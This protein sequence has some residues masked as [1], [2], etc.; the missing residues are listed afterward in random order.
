MKE[1]GRNFSGWAPEF[2][3]MIASTTAKAAAEAVVNAITSSG[4]QGN[5]SPPPP[6]SSDRLMAGVGG[7]GHAGLCTISRETACRE[8]STGQGTDCKHG[9]LPAQRSR[10]SL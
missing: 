2:S 9:L 1:G 4:V 5:Y 6:P 10:W 3:T 7:V 8:T